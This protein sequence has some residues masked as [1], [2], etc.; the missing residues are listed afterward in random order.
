MGERP[1]FET[2]IVRL[3]TLPATRV[4]VGFE[5]VWV[6]WVGWVAFGLVGGVWGRVGWVAFGLGWVW[7]GWV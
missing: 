4:W 3:L 5:L 7:V 6:G 1:T 2:V